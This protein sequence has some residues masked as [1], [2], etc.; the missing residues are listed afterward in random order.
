MKRRCNIE[1]DPALRA[2]VHELIGQ[3]CTIAQITEQVRGA[4]S[5]HSIGRYVNRY[6]KLF[7]RVVRWSDAMDMGEAMQLMQSPALASTHGDIDALCALMFKLGRRDPGL[8]EPA[9]RASLG[10]LSNKLKPK[11]A[12]PETIE[13]IK[14]ELLGLD[15]DYGL[16]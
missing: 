7:A 15:V 5:R 4:A 14:K 6:N 10:D 13:L 11:G 16:G 1:R 2:Q 12:T 9:V 3:G 8:K